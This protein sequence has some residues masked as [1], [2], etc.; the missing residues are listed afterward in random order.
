VTV[1]NDFANMIGHHLRYA[2]RRLAQARTYSLT[3]IISLTIGIGAAVAMFA[4]VHAVLLKPLPYQEPER[5]VR[6]M[7]IDPNAPK[8][9]ANYALAPQQ[10]EAWR[11]GT[12]SLSSLAVVHTSTANLTTTDT[13]YRIDAL[14]VSAEFFD[15]LGAKAQL[16]QWFTRNDELPG[17][18]RRVIL[19][20]GL[21][22][23]ALG[24]DPEI[25]GKTVLLDG[26]A[27]E[28]AGVAAGN[29]WIPAGRRLH[30]DY[31]IP[32]NVSFFLPL[33]FSEEDRRNASFLFLGLGRLAPGAT[34]AGA[35]EEL[36]SARGRVALPPRVQFPAQMHVE[37][38]QAAIVAE[39]RSMLILL[40]GAV[41]CLLLIVCVNVSNLSLSRWARSAA[42]LATRQ[43]LGATRGQLAMLCLAES[44]VL[45]AAGTA[46]GLLL[47]SWLLAGLRA[48]TALSIPRL[49]EA[50]MDWPVM[51]FALGVMVAG[52]WGAGAIPLARVVRGDIQASL[53]TVSRSRTEDG[54]TRG[55]Q[56]L[57]VGIQ[58]SLA[59]LLL[60]GAGLLLISLEK[61]L[62]VGAGSENRNVSVVSLTLPRQRYSRGVDGQML[63]DRLR[64]AWIQIPG[65][66]SVG[67]VTAL[68][69]EKSWNFINIYTPETESLPITETV[70]G[71]FVYAT[72][73][74][75]P[76]AGLGLKDGRLFADGE[77]TERVVVISQTAA[78]L[79]FPG[80]NAIGRTLRHLM[81]KQPERV[82][83]VVSDVHAEGL[84]AAP[85]VTIYRP[86]SRKVFGPMT[87][88][89]QVLVRSKTPPESIRDA[90]R[91]GLSEVDAGLA[92]PAIRSLDA[93]PRPEVERRHLQTRLVS[94][95]GL[96][97]LFLAA[98]GVYS[99]V[100]LSITQRKR[101]LAIRVALGAEAR[102]VRSFVWREALAP[103]LW[104]MA[105]GAAGA[106]A[107]A[108]LWRGVLFGVSPFDPRVLLVA[109]MVLLVATI[110]PAH[111]LSRRAERIAP[112]IAM[113]SE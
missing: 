41:C 17:A 12:G 90:L 29:L 2:V 38:L 83:G 56:R 58:A 75:F 94:G 76:T 5:L 86:L 93:L 34:A 37:P 53:A 78:E 26:V 91:K 19:S 104:G 6:V 50:A 35:A 9:W 69:T 79:L 107:L 99:L 7:G 43:A 22:R 28:I 106:V 11:T 68:P 88:E 109:S 62:A 73:N 72:Q 67:A 77:N 65:V 113:Q 42:E 102:H 18:A 48:Q 59:L 89:L 10:F 112:A 96:T 32:Q 80:R 25:V 51:L 4:I 71:S 98:I 74:Y 3:A 100:S 55:A 66:E 23:Q 47:G 45:L 70:V 64:A 63:V 111:I 54:K 1:A 49:E 81:S 95:F 110:V 39:H 20:D 46:G 85:S 36:N 97:S 13:A 24:G 15:I 31:A 57:L 105:P 82:V 84:D 103:V 33:R 61:V 14:H 16:G 92:V 21:W 108:F 101:E 60:T 30:P 87:T 27:H 8:E 40:L 44:S 52:T